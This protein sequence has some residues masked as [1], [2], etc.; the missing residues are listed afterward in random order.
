MTR[1]AGADPPTEQAMVPSS[2]MSL[3]L[4]SVPIRDARSAATP[5]AGSM[6]RAGEIDKSEPPRGPHALTPD[7]TMPAD[8][9]EVRLTNVTPAL[10][11]AL[12]IFFA[13][14]PSSV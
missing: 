9:Q 11:D 13:P 5:V 7:T 4:Q 8:V 3:K 2:A 1:T 14:L 6:R 12:P 10:K